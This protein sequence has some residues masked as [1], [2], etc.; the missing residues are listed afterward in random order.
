M[1]GRKLQKCER[2]DPNASL[3]PRNPF[4]DPVHKGTYLVYKTLGLMVG[5]PVVLLFSGYSYYT[6][7]EK[8]RPP[9]VP[10]SYLR[11]ITKRYPW[12]DG[13]H[14]F[15]HNPRTNPLKDG[16]ETSD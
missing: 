7:E 16:Y 10:Y 11:H 15:F 9:F 4:A 12:G 8:E 6:R 1:G 5:L 14:S 3:P 2:P 13:Q